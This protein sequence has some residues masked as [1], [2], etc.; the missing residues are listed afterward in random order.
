[1]KLSSLKLLFVLLTTSL[2]AAP[3]YAADYKIDTAGK[4]AFI[5]FK[6][7][8]LGYSYV[9]GEFPDFDGTFSYDASDV[10]ASKVSI[11]INTTTVDT[12]HAKRDIHIRSSDFLDVAKFPNA[13]FVSTSYLDNGDG[14]GVLTGD[15]TLHGVTQ[16][17]EL[18][19]NIVGEG[20]DPWGGYRAGFE[21][22]T[23]ITPADFGIDYNLGPA[24][25]TVDIYFSIEGIRE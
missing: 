16:P 21:G 14:Q 20:D 24:S 12:H 17:V 4:H 25:R 15:L 2:L 7:S 9:L 11:D 18:Q 22:T 5:Q 19:M 6:V 13:S 3:T 23:T 10:E 8:H 1:M